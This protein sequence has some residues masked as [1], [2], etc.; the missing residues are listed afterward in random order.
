[1]STSVI[2]RLH[3]REVATK[4]P[5]AFSDNTFPKALI[6]QGL[7]KLS[8]ALLHANSTSDQERPCYIRHQQRN[9]KPV[10][11]RPVETAPQ[12]GRS[13]FDLALILC[14]AAANGGSEPNV[15][16]AAFDINVCYSAHALN[17]KTSQGRNGDCKGEKK[18]LWRSW[19]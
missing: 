4:T 1:M 16:Y 12:C 13:L 14:A 8:S 6:Y 5:T 10:L 19:R 18:S 15:T 7:V 11:Q 2:L 9:L 3:G 17:P